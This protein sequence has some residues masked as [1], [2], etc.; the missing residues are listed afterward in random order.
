MP[1]P[2]RSSG[3]HPPRDPERPPIT[4]SD[5]QRPGVAA[6]AR[7]VIEEAAA[8]TNAS[9]ATLW[10]VSQDG[11][12]MEGALSCDPKAAILESATVPVNDSIVGMVAATG[13]GTAIGPDEKYN[14]S[15]DARTG[16]PTVAMVAVP[17]HVGEALC[18][19]LSAV[20]PRTGH[21]P[22]FDGRDLQVLHAKA[23][24]LGAILETSLTGPD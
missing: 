18:G 23:S 5:C 19:V 24:A 9:A 1:Q 8:D 16:V 3:S 22:L 6:A 21:A 7:R 11:R 2:P 15:V 17:V 4:R 20:N 12:H 13:L 10:V 14:R